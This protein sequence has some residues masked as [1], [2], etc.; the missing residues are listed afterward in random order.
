Y[1]S[2]LRR[3]PSL[4]NVEIVDTWHGVLAPTRNG[5]HIFGK[6]RDNVYASVACNAASVAR[7]S[8]A[9]ANLADYAV[10]ADTPLLRDQLS[11]PKP[12]LLPPDFILRLIVWN[13][14]RAAQATG[15]IER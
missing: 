12:A 4:R 1:E 7:G 8:A 10:G 6:M 3:W 11:F 2:I 5:G 9:G 14:R 13:R 15:D